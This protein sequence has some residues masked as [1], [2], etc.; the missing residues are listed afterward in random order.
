MKEFDINKV[1]VAYTYLSRMADGRNPVTNQSV[2]DE[3]LDN[4]NVIRCLHYVCEI[5]EEVQANNGLVGKKYSRMKEDFPLEALRK[6]E[7]R[8]DKPISHVLKQFEEP[9]EEKN[10]RRLNSGAINKW[11]AANGYIEKRI[12]QE[13]GRE[14]WFPCQKGLDIGMYSEERGEPGYQYSTIMYS[15][16]A[17]VFLA[18]HLDKIME[19]IKESKK[20]EKGKEYHKKENRREIG[21]N[22]GFSNR[23]IQSIF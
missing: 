9:V 19:G 4:P 3:I 22:Q 23:W 16:K 20:G 21:N 17:Q 7:Y 15:E 8:H 12:I 5:L 14:C 18:D 6:F 10:I 1:K 2:E 11:L 13:S